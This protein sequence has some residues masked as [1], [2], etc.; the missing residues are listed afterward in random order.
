MDA[1]MRDAVETVI[2]EFTE[3]AGTLGRHGSGFIRHGV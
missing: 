3:R 1:R 2:Q